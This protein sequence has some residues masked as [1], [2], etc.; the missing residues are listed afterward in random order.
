[1]FEINVEIFAILICLGIYKKKETCREIQHYAR[2]KPK[3]R[4]IIDKC[5]RNRFI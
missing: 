2:D 5:C 1:M 4:S 3:K